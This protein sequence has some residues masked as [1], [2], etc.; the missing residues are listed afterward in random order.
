MAAWPRWVML[1]SGLMADLMAFGRLNVCVSVRVMKWVFWVG[2][3]GFE[4]RGR[5]GFSG[6]LTLMSDYS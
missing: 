4:R 6:Y 2:V 3:L 5:P 1:D